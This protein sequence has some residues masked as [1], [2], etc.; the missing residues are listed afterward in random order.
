[1]S[2]NKLSLKDKL[3]FFF[4]IFAS[5]YIFIGAIH[6]IFS[7]LGDRAHCIAEDGLTG[8][9]WCANTVGGVSYFIDVLFW[10]LRYFSG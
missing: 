6:A 4:Y 10:P 9:F 3:G 8:L 7:V 1:M 2:D 5:L